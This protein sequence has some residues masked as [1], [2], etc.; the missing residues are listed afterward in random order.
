MLGIPVALMVSN[1]TEWFVHKHILHGLG[2]RKSSWWSFH[3]HDHHGVARRQ[4]QHDPD[5]TRPFWTETPRLKEVAALA[6][7]AVAHAPLLP[8]FPAYTATVWWRIAHY[9][10]VHKKS[11][12]DVAWAR[13]HLPW[14]VD[15]HL[16]PDQDKNWCVTHPWFDEIMGT[17]VPWVG[18]P[19]ES[20]DDAKRERLAARRAAREADTAVTA[21]A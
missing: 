2:K 4:A 9:Y 10:R 11:H 17:R 6:G 21:S 19:R 15:H 1:A 12:L 13:K 16:G 18:T 8:I 5:Y 14:H 7:L 3:W 20:E